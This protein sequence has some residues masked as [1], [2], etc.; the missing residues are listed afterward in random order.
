M[1]PRTKEIFETIRNISNYVS[2]YSNN[3]HEYSKKLAIKIGKFEFFISFEFIY[4]NFVE[5][6]E[7]KPNKREDDPSVNTS[8]QN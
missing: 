7:K 6:L 1:F 5:T 8:S 4:N 3:D 2:K